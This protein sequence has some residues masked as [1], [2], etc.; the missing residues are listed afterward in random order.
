MRSKKILYNSTTSILLQ[1]ITIIC[2]FIVGRMTLAA[3]GSEINGAVSSISQ[4]L[5]YISLLEAGIGGV[6][7]AALYKPLAERD[8]EK[9]SGIIN[10]TQG[11]FRKI[12]F[13]FIVYAGIL[14]LSFKFIS[15]SELG[16]GF[17]ATLVVILAVNTFAQYYFG[18]TYGVLINADQSEYINNLINTAALVFNSIFTVILISL[19]CS[20]H[21]V[22]LASMIVFLIKPVALFIIA[23]RKYKIKKTQ[24][25]DNAAIKQRW[26]GFGHHI[27]YYIHNNVDV[28]VVTVMLGLKWASVYS[29]YYLVVSGIKK[30]VV[31][32]GGGT[33]S[34]FGNMIAKNEKK[35]L[36][37]RFGMVENVSSIIIMVMFS[38][39]G[40]M[41][42]DFIRIYTSGISDIEYVLYP[43][44]ILFVISEALHCIKQNYHNLILAAG[45]YK[46][47]QIGAFVEAGLNVVLSVVLAFFIG[48]S[49]ILVATIISTLYRTIEYIIYL[50]KHILFRGAG[51][52]LKRM[53]VNIITALIILT[54]MFIPFGD[55]TNYFEWIFKAIPIF[56]ISCFVTFMVNIIFYPRDIKQIVLKVIGMFKRT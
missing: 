19:G 6:T 38:T 1:I 48:L 40:L 17:V 56:A 41:V 16:F 20:V 25:V 3:F 14:A 31:A 24:P 39:T 37:S 52:F 15:K 49:G 50:Q 2:G 27:A 51:P 4:F 54:C 8:N 29:V 12:A 42:F 34:A 43:V 26:N 45:H 5:G 47:T 53:G 44:G 35:I 11:F 22:K 10:A 55:P 30:I 32:F 46:E 33:E 28:M 18:I 21:I 23:K 36:L 7:R 13:I 9:I